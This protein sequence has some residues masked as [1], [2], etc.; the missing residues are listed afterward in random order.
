MGEI[1]R[2]GEFENIIYAAELARRYPEIMAVSVHPGV[3]KTEL[4]TALSLTEKAMVYASAWIQGMSLVEEDQG[5]LGQLW[6][7]AGRTQRRTGKWRL[8]YACWG[9]K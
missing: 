6:V 5:C 8:L 9:A 3:V 7:V 2:Y 1:V 4:V